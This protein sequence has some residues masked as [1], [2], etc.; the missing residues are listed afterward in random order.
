MKSLY[1]YPS[2]CGNLT[3][4]LENGV[5]TG[6]FFPSNDS[7]DQTPTDTAPAPIQKELDE[8]FRGERTEFSIPHRA[9]GTE[10][11][12]R[13]WAELA[14]IPYGETIS[15]GELARRIGNPNASRAVGMANG[16]NPISILIPCHRVIGSNKSLTGYGGGLPNKTLLLNL[17]RETIGGT[18]RFRD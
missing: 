6:L 1:S 2:P 10:F 11:Q 8:Y 5:L 16:R 13:V 3:I 4:R 17:E 14:K 9:S 18:L 12:E 15:Y 7:S